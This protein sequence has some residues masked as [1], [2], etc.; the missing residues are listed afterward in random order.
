MNT[1][2]VRHKLFWNVTLKTIAIQVLSKFKLNI[3][4]LQ[5]VGENRK[6][7]SNFNLLVKT[8][9]NF[10]ISAFQSSFKI[11]PVIGCVIKQIDFDKSCQE[12]SFS[13]LVRIS[14]IFNQIDN[15]TNVT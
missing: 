11:I 15:S 12:F 3:L 6:K 10:P 7:L 5:L 14:T 13:N 9:K 2:E 8:V 4:K 1:E